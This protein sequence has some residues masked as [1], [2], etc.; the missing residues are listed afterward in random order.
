MAVFHDEVEIEDFEY[1][2]ET[3][4]YSYPCPCGDLFLITREDLENGEDVATCPSCSLILRVIYDKIPPVVTHTAHGVQ[5]MC[6]GRL[7]GKSIWL[8]HPGKPQFLLGELRVCLEGMKHSKLP[9]QVPGHQ[10]LLR[11]VLFRHTP[12]C[13][14]WHCFGCT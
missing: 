10:L 14:S 3:R 8:K 5:I 2:E 13:T 9:M 11:D 4:T 1:D 6:S 7:C 12:V